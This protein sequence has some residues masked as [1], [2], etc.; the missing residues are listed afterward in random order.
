MDP[1]GPVSLQAELFSSQAI[2]R[3][4]HNAHIIE[5]QSSSFSVAICI[6]VINT[7]IE[8]R[9]FKN[10]V[11]CRPGRSSAM[12]SSYEKCTEYI[13]VHVLRAIWQTASNSNR[14][15]LEDSLE[16]RYLPVQ[17]CDST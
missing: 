1:A 17:S 9:L 16:T 3:T 12:T 8:F 2:R 5:L 11:S 10:C 14:I 4:I 15:S 6:T 13:L 7:N